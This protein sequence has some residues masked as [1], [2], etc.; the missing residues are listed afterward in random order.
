ML[1]GLIVVAVHKSTYVPW[2]Q[3]KT[4]ILA[5][6]SRFRLVYRCCLFHTESFGCRIPS[7]LASA[8]TELDLFRVVCVLNLDLCRGYLARIFSALLLSLNSP[9]LVEKT[10]PTDLSIVQMLF[11]YFSG[12]TFGA[13]CNWQKCFPIS[14]YAIFSRLMYLFIPI[15][16]PTLLILNLSILSELYLLPWLDSNSYAWF[17]DELFGRPTNNIQKYVQS[18]NFTLFT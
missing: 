16:V 5:L 4:D 9:D 18:R 10:S 13:N 1:F 6:I 3:K 7:N 14:H 2:Y 17:E 12:V 11:A 15:S 8:T